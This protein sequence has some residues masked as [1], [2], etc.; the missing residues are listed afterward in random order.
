MNR[1]TVAGC[2]AMVYF[3]FTSAGPR[4]DLLERL[5]ASYVQFG[6]LEAIPPLILLMQFISGLVV[7]RLR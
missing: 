7:T 5:G 4:T 6:V 1:I 2:L 3:E